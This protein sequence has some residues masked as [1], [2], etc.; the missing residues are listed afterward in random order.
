MQGSGG[1]QGDG[2]EQGEVDVFGEVV[3][4]LVEAV[5]V[6]LDLGD[7]VVGGVGVAGLVFLVPEVEVGLVLVEDELVEGRVGLWGGGGVFVTVERGLVL[8]ADDLCGIE[9]EG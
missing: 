8:Q 2:V 6:V 3:A 1:V 7:G 4:E 5:D 9:H